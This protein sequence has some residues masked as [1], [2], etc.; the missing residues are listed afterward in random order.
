MEKEILIQSVIQKCPYCLSRAHYKDCMIGLEFIIQSSIIESSDVETIE[1]FIEEIENKF[2][3]HPVKLS[4][5]LFIT[6][7]SRQKPKH[8]TIDLQVV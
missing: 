3:K 8:Y 5:F 2:Y 6:D 1:P 7:W 4:K